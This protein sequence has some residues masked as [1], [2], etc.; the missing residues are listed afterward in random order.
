MKQISVLDLK[1]MQHKTVNGFKI[2][3]NH[4]IDLK[5]RYLIRNQNQK[6]TK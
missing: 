6:N 1:I 3:K 4:A 5:S 2:I